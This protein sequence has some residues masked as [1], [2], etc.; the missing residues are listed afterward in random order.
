MAKN[1]P[2]L[3]RKLLKRMSDSPEKLS[4]V[5]DMDEEFQEI[6]DRQ[7]SILAFFWYV[8]QAIFIILAYF[9]KSIYWSI[10]ML[11]N[12][13]KI[14][15]RNIRKYKTFSFVNIFGLAVG[16]AC[17]FLI[18]LWVQHHIGFDRFH[19]NAQEIY[20]V[21]SKSEFSDG[22]TTV[23]DG[24]YYPLAS[25]LRNECPDVVSVA[26]S[27]HANNLSIKYNDT[28]FTNLQAELVDPEF[29]DIFSFPLALGSPKQ[30]L[31]ELFSILIT[32]DLAKKLFG[33]ENPLGKMVQV[34]NQLDMKI[35]GV[36]KNLP[37]NSTFQFD[38]IAPF[39][40]SLGEGAVE[41]THW[42]GNP[43][44]TIVLLHSNANLHDVENKITQTVLNHF[45]LKS[46]MKMSF[47]LHPLTNMHLYNIGGGGFYQSIIIF[48]AVAIF[49]LLIAC[50]NFMNLST[51]RAMTRAQEIGIRKT[52]GAQRSNLIKQFFGETLIMS[53]ITSLLAFLLVILLLPQFSRLIGQRFTLNELLNFNVILGFI[54]IVLVTAILSG[55]YPALFLSSF[56]PANIMK[57]KYSAVSYKSRLRKN[58][59]VF[60]FTISIFLIMVILILNKQ[61]SFIQEKDLGFEKENLTFLSMT[62][63]IENQY[64]VV[65]NE[66]LKNSNIVAVTKSVQNPLHIGSTVSSLDWDG[67]DPDKTVSWNWDYV[68]FD[69]IETFKM[70][71]IQGRTFS[72]EYS[73]DLTEG[74]IVNEEAVKMMGM[75]SPIG[76]RLSVFR[77]P[78]RIVGVVKNFHFQS[79]H[80]KIE[81]IVLGINQNWANNMFV[82]VRPENIG[83][84][85]LY[86]K[87]TCKK[88]NQQEDVQLH[89]F[90]DAVMAH[91]YRA[92]RQI[93]KIAGYLTI[94]AIFISCIG[95]FGLASFCT[96]QRSK[97]IAIRKV[98]GASVSKVVF[99]LSKDFM[100][101]VLCAN[102]LAWPIAYFVMR[103]WL[104]GFAYRTSIT[105]EILHYPDC[106]HWLS[107]LL[108]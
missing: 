38:C 78:G 29:F 9:F 106:W 19:Q 41:P 10:I 44:Q 84:T 54:C 45:P 63:N 70:E 65:K 73:T 76:Q 108:Q 26:R 74:Y 43:L 62:E 96:A 22:I 92:E 50:I 15:L 93:E 28:K 77:K 60:Q 13:I 55:S 86:I 46:I 6:S 71:I 8:R 7:G 32:E 95:L 24:S 17:C 36:L 98:M 91:S 16:I 40:L 48:S 27:A 57:G 79:L 37:E 52:V 82:R 107:P 47:H 88:F 81:P 85:V 53:F 72:P 102:V 87:D 14:S 67:K 69:Y 97:E 39:L 23:F 1:P 25:V 68:G 11:K 89:F 64:D 21:W 104:V 56:S 42:G 90:D 66:L 2:K 49:V 59:V 58:L 101:W 99:S 20:Q 103:K 75:E 80:S 83:E 30:A 5:G 3:A 18:F 12:Y 34:N 100:I 94:L 51:A 4:I 33:N 105:V 31:A 61:M 35:T